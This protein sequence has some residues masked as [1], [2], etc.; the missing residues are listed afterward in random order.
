ME[1]RAQ[2]TSDS[3]SSLARTESKLELCCPCTPQ[4]GDDKGVEN[5]VQR[6]LN[7]TVRGFRR[8]AEVDLELHP[9]TV[10]IG[11]NGVGKSSLLDTL[12]ILASSAQGNL[13]AAVSECPA[14]ARS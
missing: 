5:S 7:L 6:F 9:L 11:A 1:D 10:L 3:K 2:K 13:N 14:W 8:L 4:L 12:S